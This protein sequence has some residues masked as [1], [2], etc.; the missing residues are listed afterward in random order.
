MDVNGVSALRRFIFG[1]TASP[2]PPSAGLR[3][4]YIFWVIASCLLGGCAAEPKVLLVYNLDTL[5]DFQ[6]DR[7]PTGLL[8]PEDLAAANLYGRDEVAGVSL[9]RRAIVESSA[10]TVDYGRLIHYGLFYLDRQGGHDHS[11]GLRGFGPAIHRDFR[12]TFIYSSH[13]AAVE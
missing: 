13:G 4:R 12:R 7:E 9:N 2:P 3:L 5:L 10:G 6:A 8:G 1:T 11:G